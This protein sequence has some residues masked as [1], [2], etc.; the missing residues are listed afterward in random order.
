VSVPFIGQMYSGYK[1]KVPLSDILRNFGPPNGALW[2]VLNTEEYPTNITAFR[3]AIAYAINYTQLYDLYVYNGTAF[4]QPFFG[5]ISPVFPIYNEVMAMDHLHPYSYNLSLALHY[6]NEAGYEGHFYVILPNGTLIGDPSGTQLPTIPIYAITPLTA[7]D[8][9]ELEI[10]TA[11][12]QQIG[13]SATVRLVT[14]SY[15]DSWVSPKAWPPIVDLGWGPDWPD[16]IFQSLV[17]TTD[18]QF[19]GLGGDEAW[20]NVSWVTQTD[21]YLPFITNVT[22]QTLL[23]AKIYAFLYNYAPYINIPNVDNYYFVQPYIVNM[24]YNSFGGYWYNTIAY[25]NFTYTE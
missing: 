13:I 14:A 17:A 21:S 18:I 19:G 4:A 20:I 12:L 8:Q 15:T 25:E 1:Y 6:L 22:N 11:D 10:I 9:E 2:L 3:L 16:P 24:T 5:P 23:V 7:I